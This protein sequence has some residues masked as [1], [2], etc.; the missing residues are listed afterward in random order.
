MRLAAID[1][2]TL[3]CRLLIA[4]LSTQPSGSIS[5]EELYRDVRITQLGAGL[6]KRKALNPEGREALRQALEEYVQLLERFHVVQA[7]AVAT[8]A[9]RD[10]LAA[11]AAV[12]LGSGG[13]AVGGD[14]GSGGGVAARTEL[15][16][17][18]L[19][20]L[21]GFDPDDAFQFSVISGE[22]EARLAFTGATWERSGSGLLVVD[23]GGGSTEYVLG[24]AG[25]SAT[26]QLRF[27]RSLQ[28][29]SRRLTD[30]YLRNDP[31]TPG[32]LAALRTHVAAELELLREDL[33]R[34]AGTKG[35]REMIAVAGTATTMVTM[36]YGIEPYNRDQVHGQ[37]ITR[38]D[39]ELLLEA[40]ITRPLKERK[41]IP[42]LDPKRAEVIIAGTLILALTLEMLE[43]PQYTASDDDLLQGILVGHTRH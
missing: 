23:P 38:D 5:L 15:G 43:L 35:I 40:L 41:K 11:Q 4:E 31:P 24:D 25:G 1:I 22:E 19:Q 20:K 12:S 13:A 29:G 2:G 21:V 33:L 28:L 14:G 7:R 3:T 39:L 36:K 6:S 16:S 17:E 27:A 30:A 26:P 18:T 42:G 37:I 32:E 9:V 34:A 10:A 8:S